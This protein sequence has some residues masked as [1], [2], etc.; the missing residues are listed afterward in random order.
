[1]TI[2]RQIAC[3]LVQWKWW[4]RHNDQWFVM[5]SP[6]C[7]FDG[8][9]GLCSFICW[10]SLMLFEI[11]W[12]VGYWL[13]LRYTPRVWVNWIIMSASCLNQWKVLCRNGWLQ[14]MV[15]DAIPFIYS[16]NSVFFPTSKNWFAIPV[17]ITEIDWTSSIPVI[18]SEIRLKRHMSRHFLVTSPIP[19]Y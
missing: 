2:S 5:A 9:E 8:K 6:C 17:M 18:N 14:H 16:R 7:W 19:H 4:A 13:L 10:S 1:M 11:C 15:L 3:F 12:S